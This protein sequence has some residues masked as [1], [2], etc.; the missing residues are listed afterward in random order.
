LNV[1]GKKNVKIR[2]TSKLRLEKKKSLKLLHAKYKIMILRNHAQ[3]K[4]K[5]K[6]FTK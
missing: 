3:E 5:K 1:K 6:T 2:R 4:R